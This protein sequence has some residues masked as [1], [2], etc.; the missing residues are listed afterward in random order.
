LNREKTKKMLAIFLIQAPTL[1]CWTDEEYVRH[2][3]GN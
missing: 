3:G 1:W 2:F